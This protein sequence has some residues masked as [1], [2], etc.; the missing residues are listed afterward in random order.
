MKHVFDHYG[1]KNG[2]D[3]DPDVPVD[4]AE[5]CETKLEIL[6]NAIDDII[7]TCRAQA[8]NTASL[9]IMTQDLKTGEIVDIR[10][11]SKN[12]ADMIAG[13]K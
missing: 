9:N 6:D 5:E 3:A 11:D 13:L 8:I 10:R 4:P 1:G 12:D 7:D 2:E